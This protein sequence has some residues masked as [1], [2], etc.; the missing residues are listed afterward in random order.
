MKTLQHTKQVNGS[1]VMSSMDIPA[2]PP[3]HYV[4]GPFVCRVTS[5]ALMVRMKPLTCQHTLRTPKKY[6]WKSTNLLYQDFNTGD[7][8]L[9]AGTE[10]RTESMFVS[11]LNGEKAGKGRVGG[12]GRDTISSGDR[13]RKV[14]IKLTLVVELLVAEKQRTQGLMEI[15]SKRGGY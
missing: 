12:Q 11:N 14:H 4:K 13:H 2:Q 6:L 3:Q 5:S 10:Q 1:T 9:I 7:L 8:I 15:F